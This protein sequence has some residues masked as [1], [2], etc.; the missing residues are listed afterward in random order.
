MGGEI[1]KLPELPAESDGA[2][3]R[4]TYDGGPSLPNETRWSSVPPIRL[5]SARQQ[6]LTQRN[7]QVV[8]M[9][10]TL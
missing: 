8:D 6:W 9:T 4:T 7:R 10:A 2:V 1:L 5:V 3:L